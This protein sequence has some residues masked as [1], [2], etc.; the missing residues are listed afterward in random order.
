MVGGNYSSSS[1]DDS[2]IEEVLRRPHSSLKM[3]SKPCDNRGG[4]AALT[5]GKPN[6]AVAV[7]A[8]K[9]DALQHNTIGNN[10]VASDDSDSSS[11]S[12][13]SHSSSSSC[14]SSSSIEQIL[15]SSQWKRPSDD[16]KSKI[17][18]LKLPLEGR[19]SEGVTS[20]S[21]L[22]RTATG[23]RTTKSK[24]QAAGLNDS[25]SSKLG[26]IMQ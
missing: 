8:R 7:S 9:S 6:N 14:S 13:G 1:S 22:A 26:T 12:D 25:I 15:K 10:D 20:C 4:G 24:G 5:F 18:Y 23:Q 3:T 2:S 21:N 19:N 17:T 11:S 16:G